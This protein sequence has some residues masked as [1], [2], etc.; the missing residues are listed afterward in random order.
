VTV[1]ASTLY[2]QEWSS[3]DTRPWLAPD[4]AAELTMAD[5]RT[6]RDPAFEAALAYQA[7]PQGDRARSRER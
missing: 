4:I 2:W 3:T 5:Y 1:R 7:S 6:N